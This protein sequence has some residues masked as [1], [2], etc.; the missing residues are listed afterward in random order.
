MAL[1]FVILNLKD[2][3]YCSSGVEMELEQLWQFQHQKSGQNTFYF[4][5]SIETVKRLIMSN[6]TDKCMHLIYLG[7]HTAPVKVCRNLTKTK[8]HTEF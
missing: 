6:N 4:C 5:F 7:H 3:I 1:F 2:Q 8:S